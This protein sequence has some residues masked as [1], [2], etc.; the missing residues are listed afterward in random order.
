LLGAL[1]NKV[2]HSF[3][4]INWIFHFNRLIFSLYPQI[5][6][7]MN[8]TGRNSVF[9]FFLGWKICWLGGF[10]FL[11]N[12]EKQGFFEFSSWLN[13]EIISFFWNDC[14]ILYG[15]PVCSQKYRRPFAFLLSYFLYPDL[16][17]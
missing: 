7:V 6:L 10:F 8:T 1:F 5:I 13:I 15:V 16:P 9:L 17:K 14:Q 4:A 11:L 2:Y 12:G 3:I